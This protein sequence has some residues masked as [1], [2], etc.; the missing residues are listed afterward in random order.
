MRV[1]VIHRK[2]DGSETRFGTMELDHMPPVGEPF[3]LDDSTCYEARGYFGPDDD[4]N[5]L[6]I[7]GGEPQPMQSAQRPGHA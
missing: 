7:L 3:P 6:L 5:Y 1:Q 4:G 2:T